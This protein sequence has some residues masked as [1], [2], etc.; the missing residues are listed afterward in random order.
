MLVYKTNDFFFEQAKMEYI[1]YQRWFI[2]HKACKRET[3]KTIYNVKS[4][5]LQKGSPR[6]KKQ[7]K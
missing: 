7:A 6:W 2:L 4:T 3:S 5:V 1:D